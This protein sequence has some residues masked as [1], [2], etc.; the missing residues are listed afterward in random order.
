MLRPRKVSAQASQATNATAK[1][2][3]VCLHKKYKHHTNKSRTAPLYIPGF[4]RTVFTI[5]L[6]LST[7]RN[8]LGS[9]LFFGVDFLPIQEDLGTTAVALFISLPRVYCWSTP[10]QLHSAARSQLGAFIQGSTSSSQVARLMTAESSARP[11]RH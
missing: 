9:D 3:S 6:P 11:L 8:F 7:G 10:L 5:I 1:F 2:T 4:A